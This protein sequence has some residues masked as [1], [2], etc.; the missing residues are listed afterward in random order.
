MFGARRER[1]PANLGH[2]MLGRLHRFV[3]LVQAADNLG[4]KQW[5]RLAKQAT[6]S[7][8]RDCVAIGLEEQARR[9]ISDALQ[10]QKQNK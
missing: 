2:F 9:I 1:P 7:A 8:Y 6:L 4:L 10:S 3:G 5:E